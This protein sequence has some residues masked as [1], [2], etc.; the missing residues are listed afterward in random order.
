MSYIQDYIECDIKTLSTN[1]LFR[2]YIKR[3]NNRLV[4]KVKDGHKLES[5]IPKFMKLFGS[6]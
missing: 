5:R 3:I 2:I 6:T 1:P 4:F